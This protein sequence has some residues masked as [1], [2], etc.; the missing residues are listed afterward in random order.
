MLNNKGFAISTILYSLLMMATLILFL[1][2]GTLSFERRTTTNLAN[3][4]KDELNSFVNDDDNH[5]NAILS[6]V[7]LNYQVYI[8]G[9]GWDDPKTDGE[10]AGTTSQSR[11]IQA[12]KV[13]IENQSSLSGD[14]EYRAHMQTYGWQNYVKN[15]N[16][17]GL[18]NE[19]KRLE[20]FEIRLTGDLANYFDIEYRAH[21]Q[22]I[23]WQSY[24]KNGATAGTIGKSY[25][26]E[27]IQIRLV[28]KEHKK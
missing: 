14:I 23:G 20:A 15:G 2:V 18:I 28:R 25:R 21:V 6:N 5:M 17:A 26:I 24:V 7:K 4:I 27:A 11:P 16:T 8:S 22:N 13:A 12:M 3:D 10:T 9:T 1:L 19:E